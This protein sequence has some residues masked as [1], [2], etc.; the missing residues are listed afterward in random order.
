MGTWVERS[1]FLYLLLCGI[2]IRLASDV[3]D[4]DTVIIARTDAE[5]AKLL[6]SDIDELDRKFMTGKRTPEGFFQLQEGRGLEFGC[7]RGQAYAEYADLWCET[8]KPCL[9][10]AKQFADAVKGGSGCDVGIQLFTIVQLEKSIPSDQ[11]LHEYEL[12]NRIQV[13]VYHIGWI[14]FNESGSVQLFARQYKNDGMLAY[15]DLQ[16]AEFSQRTMDTLVHVT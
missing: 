1:W 9:K 16:E 10:E 13:P 14:P 12:G 2:S 8:S 6:S 15:A 3:A 11:E 5:S 7:E 4:T